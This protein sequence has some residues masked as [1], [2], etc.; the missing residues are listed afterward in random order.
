MEPADFVSIKFME[1][2][3]LLEEVN[4]ALRRKGTRPSTDDEVDY[5]VEICMPQSLLEGFGSEKGLE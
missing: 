3:E 2:T 4:R 1:F 5:T